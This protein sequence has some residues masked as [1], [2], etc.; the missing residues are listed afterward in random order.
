MYGELSRDEARKL[1]NKAIDL[2]INLF[3]T[4]DV[5]GRGRAEELLGEFLRGVDGVHISTKVGYDFYSGEKP[6]RRFDKQYIEY[7]ARLSLERLGKKPL[8]LMLHNPSTEDVK[9]AAPWFLEMRGRVADLVGAALGPETNVLEQGLAAIGAGMDAVMLV[10]N[11]LEQEPAL[12]LIRE[13]ANRGVA[14]LARVPHATGVLTDRPRLDYP[15]GDHRSLRPRE[16][17]M[18]AR[19]IVERDVLPLARETGYTLAQYA[20]KFVLTF[21]VT[22]VV[23]TAT[24]PEELEEYAAASD[25]KPLPKHHIEELTSAYRRWAAELP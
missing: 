11:I 6:V 19:R 23:V 7:A 3:D 10:F 14:V 5:Y 18:A 22:T 8:L 1:V 15:A 9:N 24:T 12:A 4:A 13:A 16:W 21:P 20:I 2:G 25:G 17:L